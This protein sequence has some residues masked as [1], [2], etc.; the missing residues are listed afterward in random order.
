MPK[1]LIVDDDRDLRKISARYLAEEGFDI[2]EAATNERALRDFSEEKLDVIL[3]DIQMP[4]SDH[5]TLVPAFR[6]AHPNVKIIIFS[7][8][9]LSYQQEMV[10]NA[11]GYFNKMDG[12][13]QL[14]TKI[15]DVLHKNPV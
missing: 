13:R 5:K 14:M 12:N 8:H 6:K 9:E 11:D 4:L 10:P 3:L 2:F 15:R 7:C 1:I